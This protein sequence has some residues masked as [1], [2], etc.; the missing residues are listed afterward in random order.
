MRDVIGDLW[1]AW[2]TKMDWFLCPFRRTVRWKSLWLGS[3]SCTALDRKSNF[4]RE[5]S[6]SPTDLSKKK[7]IRCVGRYLQA[8]FDFF[9]WWKTGSPWGSPS[10]LQGPKDILTHWTVVPITWPSWSLWTMSSKECH[11]GLFFWGLSVSEWAKTKLPE[12][13]G[14]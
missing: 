11:L 13:K 1:M 6:L 14:F 12:R 2:G 5:T 8:V 4:W 10:W 7:T 9:S 3:P